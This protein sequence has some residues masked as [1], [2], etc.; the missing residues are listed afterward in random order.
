MDA[1]PD[2][3]ASPAISSF[4]VSPR[5]RWTG[6]ART[7]GK[8]SSAIAKVLLPKDYLRLWL[9]GEH[10]SDMSDAAGTSWL[11]TGAR[12]WS[13]TLLAKCHLTRAHMP[14]WWRAQRCRGGCAARSP[15]A[16]AFLTAYRLPAAA[17]TMPPRR[18]GWAW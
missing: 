3:R 7:T 6:F 15:S 5:Q 2:F 8:S 11:D 16:S 12:D 9:T 18:S 4:P 10:A 14:R 13:D 1:D 17:A